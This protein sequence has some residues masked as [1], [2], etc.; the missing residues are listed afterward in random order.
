MAYEAMK[1]KVFL[2]QVY[3][4]PNKRNNIEMYF[5]F[6]FHLKNSKTIRRLFKAFEIPL[7]MLQIFHQKLIVFFS[8]VKNLLCERRGRQ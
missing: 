6:A 4:L 2:S 3:F 7:A 8:Q 5:S 1:F